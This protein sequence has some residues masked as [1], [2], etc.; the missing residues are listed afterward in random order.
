M[1][2]REGKLPRITHSGTI[3]LVSGI[4]MVFVGFAFGYQTFSI[5]G[6]AVVLAITLAAFSTFSVPALD[7]ERVIEPQRVAR[8]NPAHGLVSVKNTR[9]GRSRACSAVETVGEESV[10]VDIP[11]LGPRRSI[12]VS[13]DLS[14]RRRGE[15]VVG[16]LAIRRQDPLGLFVASRTVGDIATVLV[17]PKIFTLDP[18][19]S[20]RVRHIEG[21]RSDK[22]TQGTMTFHSLREYTRGD[23]I[24][25]VHWRSSARTGTLMV[26]ENV[27]TSLPST[28]VVLDTYTYHYNNDRFEDAVDVAASVIAASQARNFPVRFL[29]TSGTTLLVRAGQRGQ[30]LRNLLATVA[31]DERGSLQRTTGEVLRGHDHDTIVVIAGSVTAEDLRHVSSMA[32]RFTTPILVTVRNGGGPR[33]SLGMHLD[34]EDAES[35]LEGWRLGPNV[36]LTGSSQ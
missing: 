27:D 4:A 15:L 1:Q 17:E 23:D 16:P 13:Y 9:Q 6:V 10:A 30:E 25:H 33:W 18:R 35:A 26:R 28:V 2:M 19:P 24:R 34:G 29:T 7:V 21:P 5:A 8:G 14:T 36:R 11:S 12:V 20:G 22:S 3:V 32:G 31:V